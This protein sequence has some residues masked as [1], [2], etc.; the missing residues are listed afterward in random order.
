MYKRTRWGFA[1]LAVLVG[2]CIWLLAKVPLKLGIDLR[3]GTLLTYSLDLSRIEHNP[4]AVAEQVKDIIAKRLNAY[5]LKEISVQ[6]QGQ[7]HLVVRLPG[8]DP[9]AVEGIK[10]QVETA[11]NLAFR[12]VSTTEL[13]TPE[14][15]KQVEEEERT[16]I[17]N[18][19]DWVA[20]KLAALRGSGT[21]RFSA[22]QR[23]IVAHQS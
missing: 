10:K 14:A 1:F 22:I 21:G 20:R 15:Q 19:R 3:G 5:G 17:E 2:L 18:D 8:S 9:E 7:D 23:S 6:V 12:L 13:Q 16:Y 11:G 4:G